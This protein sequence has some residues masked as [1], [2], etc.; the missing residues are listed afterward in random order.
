MGLS[1]VLVASFSALAA[2]AATTPAYAQLTNDPKPLTKDCKFTQERPYPVVIVHGQAGNVEGM[3]GVTDRLT[4]EGYCV[5]GTNYGSIVEGINGQDHLWN[6]AA[7]IGSF[8]DVVLDKTERKMVEVVGHS[9]GTG[10]LDNYILQRGGASK[11]H[12]FVSFGGL[13]HPYW[14]LG[15]PKYFDIDIH[16]PNLWAFGQ[17]FFPGLTID[18]LTDIIAGMVGDP[19]LKSTINSR[20]AEDLFDANYW[21]ILHGGPSEPPGVFVKIMSQGRTLPTK[22]SVPGVCNTNI[23][24]IG[25]MLVGGA[26]GWQDVAP[27]ID[28]FL[29]ETVI[30]GNSHND[31]LGNKEALDRMIAGIKRTC[32]NMAMSLTPQSLSPLDNGVSGESSDDV[33]AKRETRQKEFGEDFL[34]AVDD[35]YGDV[36]ERSDTPLPWEPGGEDV[37]SGAPG[38][39]G[40]G[41]NDAQE[42]G[43]DGKDQS[44]SACSVGHVGGD[45]GALATLFGALGLAFVARS[46]KGLRRRA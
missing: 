10:V 46:R 20:F 44:L 33:E 35:K 43:G 7:Q 23:V 41:S 26:A 18:Q 42:Q 11:V 30:T 14:H 29:T 45:R 34:R 31:M 21:N 8:I 17:Q 13:H 15:V 9:A 27:H 37:G 19:G 24:A 2:L 28:N 39:G 40:Q 22:D 25:D 32:G 1:R 3:Q 5:Y 38:K 6:S 36:L 16:L 12:S 4:A